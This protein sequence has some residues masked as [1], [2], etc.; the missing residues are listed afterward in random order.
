LHAFGDAD[1]LAR[2]LP[3]GRLLKARSILELR[4]RPERLV[5]IS[6]RFLEESFRDAEGRGSDVGPIAAS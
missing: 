5:D 2:R 6:R 1:E 3:N 4:L